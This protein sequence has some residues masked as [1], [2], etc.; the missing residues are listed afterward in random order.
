MW[1]SAGERAGVA[2]DLGDPERADTLAEALAWHPA[3]RLV[4]REAAAVVIGEAP[5]PGVL[6][7]SALPP[8]AP[9]DLVL[10]AAVV[11]AAGFRLV[12]GEPGREPGDVPRLTP[13]EREVLGLMVEGASNKA[14]A[15][16]LGFSARTAKFHVGAVLGKLGAR[17]RAEAV[18]RALR[19]GIGGI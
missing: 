8:D 4:P 15:R 19:E 18:A 5:G 3:L 1:G 13:R 10:A 16:T 14:I 2:L 11:T 17:N 12:P 6:D 7:V 9:V